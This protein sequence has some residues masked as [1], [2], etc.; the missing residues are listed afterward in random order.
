MD[1]FFESDEDFE[2]FHQP[3]TSDDAS[4]M[5]GATTSSTVTYGVV[6]IW[7][8]SSGRCLLV[9]FAAHSP[10]LSPEEVCTLLSSRFKELKNLRQ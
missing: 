5:S 8:P 10:V 2:A 7:R 9:A 4:C 6:N 3:S 1:S